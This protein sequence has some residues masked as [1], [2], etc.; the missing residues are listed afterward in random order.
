M[1]V[2]P[3]GLFTPRKRRYRARDL[4]GKFKAGIGIS[5]KA[6]TKKGDA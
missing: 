1:L 6:T 2:R 3:H 5:A 4:I